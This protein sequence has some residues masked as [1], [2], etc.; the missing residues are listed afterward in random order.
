MASTAK[1][2][3]EEMAQARE[4]GAIMGSTN[5]QARRAVK[6]VKVGPTYREYQ[7]RIIK[8]QN[9]FVADS[10]AIRATILAATG[11]GKT[12]CFT[13]L[14]I[15]MFKD[16]IPKRILIVHPRLALSMSQQKRL[17]KDLKGVN[18]EFTSFHSG[19]VYHTL[20]TRKNRST[21]DAIELEKIR[22]ESIGS[23]IT[24]SSYK[25]L[26]KI[27][28]LDYDLIIC[29]EAHYLVQSDLRNNLHLFKS[30]VLFY[31]GTPIKVAAQEESMD[32]IDLFG[33]VIAEVPPSELIPHGYIVAPL[34]R[35][36]NAR[37]KRKGNSIDYPTTIAHAYK[38]QL[39]KVN[40]KFNHKMLVAMAS[41]EY[42]EEIINELTTIRKIVNDYNLDVYY[43]TAD[44]VSKNGHITFGADAREKM[45]DDFES[46][47]N[48]CI[49]IHCDTLAEGI[50]IDG[51]GGILLL[52]N[53]SMAKSI[54]TIGRGCRAA[55]AD[56]CK[57]GEIR[58]NRIKTNCIVTL[59]RVDNEWMGGAKTDDYAT[60]F[61]T[62]GYGNLYD[63]IDPECAG[64]G[65]K[66]VPGE[67][68]DVV[69][70]Q[71]E[72]IK[73]TEIKNALWNELFSDP[74]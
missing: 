51:I 14:L 33:P 44:R 27:A 72:D 69:W 37:T 49:I 22:N 24:F 21:T 63:L 57:N 20:D 55:K 5:R 60:L 35:Y 68:D 7:R 48:R 42:F 52:R 8:A 61:E 32:N 59:V 1:F 28:A 30:K 13:D 65:K 45:L 36:L 64:H 26:H 25:S 62:A 50:D 53:L 4:T 31:T 29:D 3:G 66:K 54:Q 56:I 58:K 10:L 43:V 18:V 73:V 47:T 71:I 9:D 70:D 41:T 12:V 2:I 16:K 67:T 11:A 34:I 6:L 23:H 40:P 19:E 38:D 74:K 17:K 15:Q 46:N 39:T